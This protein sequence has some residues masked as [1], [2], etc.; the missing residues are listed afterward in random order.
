MKRIPKVS[1]IIAV[2]NTEQYIKKCLDSII[3]QTFKDMEIIVINDGSTD[4]SIDFINEYKQKDERVRVVNLDRNYGICYV[5]NKGIE[6]SKGEYIVFIDSDDWVSKDYIEFL[7]DNIEKEKAD[8]VSTSFYFYND[9]TKEYREYKIPKFYCNNNFS[10]IKQK[11]K[12]VSLLSFYKSV[13]WAKIYNKNFLLKN[14][15]NFKLKINEDELFNYEF[16]L[17]A[18]KI[19]FINNP[20]YFYR[21][22]REKALMKNNK[23]VF[24]NVIQVLKKIKLLLIKRKVYDIYAFSFL[25]FCLRYLAD[26]NVINLVSEK[27]SKILLLSLK[28]NLQKTDNNLLDRM[29]CFPLYIFLSC[30]LI[31]KEIIKCVRFYSKLRSFF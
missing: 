21:R 16:F 15:L 17:L 22:N 12:L 6:C 28:R 19:K 29:I 30:S 31:Q 7:Y 2:Y 23:F 5:R 26:H 8:M 20:I 1:I 3:N 25:K 13:L 11:Q 10:N 9:K 27:K 14:N 4:S 24:F 18:R